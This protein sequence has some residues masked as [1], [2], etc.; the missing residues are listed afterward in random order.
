MGS[1]LAKGSLAPESE[2]DPSRLVEHPNCKNSDHR[3]HPWAKPVL[4]VSLA[5]KYYTDQETDRIKVSFPVIRGWALRPCP[6]FILQGARQHVYRRWEDSSDRHNF[7]KQI[8]LQISRQQYLVKTYQP[9]SSVLIKAF[10][11]RNLLWTHF[12]SFS[13]LYYMD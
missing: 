6:A 13:K 12:H 4:T 11:I 8:T 5:K 1:Q 10:R 3:S 9:P 2:P 7:Y